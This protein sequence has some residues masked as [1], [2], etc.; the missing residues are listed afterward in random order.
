MTKL[1]VFAKLLK[2][3]KEMSYLNNT[4]IPQPPSTITNTSLVKPTPENLLYDQKNTL[5]NFKLL[6]VFLNFF[7]YLFF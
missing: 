3:K 5:S 1:Q 2:R 7:I 4:N 6:S